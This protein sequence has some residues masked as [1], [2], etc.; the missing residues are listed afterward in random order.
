MRTP[1]L[2]LTLQLCANIFANGAFS[3]V[4]LSSLGPTQKLNKNISTRSSLGFVSRN[5]SSASRMFNGGSQDS[6]V[7]ENNEDNESVGTWNPLR[8]AVLKLGFTEL[9]FTSPLN[10]EKRDGS[11]NCANCGSKLFDSKG[12]YDSGSG[13][14]SFWKTSTNNVVGLEQEWD[15]RVECV[16]KNCGGHLGHVFPDG[17]QRAE[18]SEMELVTIPDTDPKTSNPENSATRLPRFCVNG[19]SLRFSPDE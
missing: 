14:P 6:D 7:P 16:C 1:L 11:Y 18:V 4:A 19:A 9:R 5:R 17:P 10:Y 12:K 2:V 13:W 15:G 3:G 8:L